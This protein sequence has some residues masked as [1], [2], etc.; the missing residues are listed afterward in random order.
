MNN[1]TDKAPGF[2][3]LHQYISQGIIPSFY[4]YLFVLWHWDCLA[5]GSLDMHCIHD[6]T[7]KLL[8]ATYTWLQPSYG[9]WNIFSMPSASITGPLRLLLDLQ[10]KHTP[11][12]WDQIT[13][14]RLHTPKYCWCP[15]RSGFNYSIHYGYVYIWKR[16]FWAS[17]HTEIYWAKN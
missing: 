4:F 14:H 1:E 7:W 15:K 3:G 9:Q 16:I 13:F 2:S 5:T 6:L 8:M 12:N 17:D 10:H 11:L